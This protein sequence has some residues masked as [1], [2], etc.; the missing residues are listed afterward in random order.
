MLERKVAGER[1]AGGIERS[2]VERR[3][4]RLAANSV[5]AEEFFGHLRGP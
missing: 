3:F 4:A 2:V 5:G 1:A